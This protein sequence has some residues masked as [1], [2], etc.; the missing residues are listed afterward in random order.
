V[1]LKNFKNNKEVLFVIPARSGSKGVKNKNLKLC[2]GESLLRRAVKIAKEINFDSRIIVST[3]SEIYLK[4][5]EDLDCSQG[6]LRTSYLSGDSICDIEVLT[7]TLHA[8]EVEYNENYK[9]VTMLQPTSPL[10]K[11]EHIYDSVNAVIKDLW[12]ASLTANKVDLKYHPLKSLIISAKGSSNY[13]LEEGAKIISRQMLDQTYI[14][15]GACYSIT[16]S[17][18]TTLK[19]F[20]GSHSKIIETEEMIS[21]DSQEEIIECENILLKRKNI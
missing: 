2:A 16:P 11:K 18:L 1:N 15:N 13:Y 21:I 19:T 14:R 12:D 8:A 20:I 5:V 6:F 3:D 7:Q 4:H 9:C 10:R 17:C